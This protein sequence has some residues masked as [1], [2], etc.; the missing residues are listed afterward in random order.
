MI[1]AYCPFFI[2]ATQ[3]RNIVGMK[4]GC[5][6]R[7]IWV[8]NIFFQETQAEEWIRRAHLCV[9][10]ERKLMDSYNKVIVLRY[11]ITEIQNSR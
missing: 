5:K 7:A 8:L 3:D 10:E 6:W 4:T 11:W 1:I 9:K 2:C